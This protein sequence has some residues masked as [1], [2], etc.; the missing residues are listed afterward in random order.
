[1]V[2]SKPWRSAADKGDDV[3]EDR[4]CDMNHARSESRNEI[5]DKLRQLKRYD[6]GSADDG[7]GY[8]Y[9]YE[10]VSP[11]G[12]WVEWDDIQEVIDDLVR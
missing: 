3:D 1:M 10:D 7:D 8:L 9:D 2:V 11:D 12:R 4:K 6:A 5:A